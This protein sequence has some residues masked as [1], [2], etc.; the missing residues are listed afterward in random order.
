MKAFMKKT[1]SPIITRLISSQTSLEKGN[2]R[3]PTPKT[4]R[5]A[6]RSCRGWAPPADSIIQTISAM[7]AA[8]ST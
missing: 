6:A 3:A 1:V 8:L 5:V 4:A 7:K 2:S